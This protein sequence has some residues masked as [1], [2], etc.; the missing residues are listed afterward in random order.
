MRHSLGGS[1][2]K[3]DSRVLF[4]VGGP[5]MSKIDDQITSRVS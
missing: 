2:L 1:D 3:V 4:H 5:A